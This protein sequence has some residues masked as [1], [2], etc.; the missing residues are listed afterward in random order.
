MKEYQDYFDSNQRLWD[1]KTDIHVKSEFYDMETFLKGESSLRKIELAALPDLRGKSLLH[2]QCHF[3]QD[4]LSLERLGAEC[5]AIDLSENGIRKAKEIRDSLGMHSEFVQGN[6]LETDKYI[7]ALF[8]VVY[9]SYGVIVWLPD[10]SLWAAQVAKRLKKGG[11]FFMAEFHSTMY[12]FDWDKN[13][14]AY[15]Y[16]NNGQPYVEETDGTYANPEADI[17]MKE[18]FWQH[19]LSDVLQSLIDEGLEIIEF[20][21]YDYSP[22]KL[23]DCFEQRTEQEYVYKIKG[24]ALPSVFMLKAIKK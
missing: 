4:T 13:Q 3:G 8:D 23:S 7:S 10:L 24:I 20:K 22:Y 15:N 2:L 11:L 16:F 17:K 21:E 14:V 18:H 9:T 1:K 6:V 5:T 12:L 19:P